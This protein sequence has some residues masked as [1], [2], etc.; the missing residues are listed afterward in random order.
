VENA[1]L[2][3][4]LGRAQILLLDGENPAYNEPSLSHALS[5][6][7]MIVSFGNFIDDSVAYADL[8]LPDHHSLESDLAVVPA[9]SPRTAVTVSTSFVRPL[10]NTRPIEQTLAEIARKMSIAFEAVSAKSFVEPLLPPG[11]VWDEV[12]RQGGLWVER[13]PEVAAVK[14]L[15]L[16]VEVAVFSGAPEQFPLLFQPYLSLQYHDGRGANLPWMQ[17]LPDPVSSSMWG[18]PLE[19]DPQTAAKLNVKT[20]DWVR[21]ESANGALEAPAY[22][23]P[24][25]L[26]GVVGMAIGQG[27]TTY[28]RYASGRGA[29]PLSILSP[30]WE[31]TTGTLVTGGTR[32]RVA[33]LEKTGELIQFSPQ[34]R[35]QGPWGYR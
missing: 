11:Q 31:K 4:A 17:E 32:V 5:G 34:D 22:V 21:V 26:P 30:V 33:R 23:H 12:A 20:G 14:P 24:A 28:G 35:E 2:A 19:I 18:L 6:L 10:Y 1:N 9:V 13:G 25:A 27:H 7:E 15:K 29:N 3:E 8:I 16:E